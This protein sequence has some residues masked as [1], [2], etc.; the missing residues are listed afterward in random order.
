M[1]F[2]GVAERRVTRYQFGAVNSAALSRPLTGR[3]LEGHY[4]WTCAADAAADSQPA[5]AYRSEQ[6]KLDRRR[7]RRA[8]RSAWDPTT[9][10]QSRTSLAGRTCSPT[11]RQP[12]ALGMG[13]GGSTNMLGTFIPNYVVAPPPPKPVAARR[14]RLPLADYGGRRCSNGEADA[15][16]DSGI[17]ARS[18]DRRGSPAWF[19]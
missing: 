19:V 8:V 2:P 12:L 18:R 13:G 4:G 7:C 6:H 3:S 16:S 11:R 5:R 1:E 9:N 10:A 14:S 17:S 15:E